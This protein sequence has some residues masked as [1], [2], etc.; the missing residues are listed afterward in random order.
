MEKTSGK[1]LIQL[2]GSWGGGQ[3]LGI[4]TLSGDD[5]NG[6]REHKLDLALKATAT[7]V[8]GTQ[9][10]EVEMNQIFTNRETKWVRAGRSSEGAYPHKTNHAERMY[11]RHRTNERKGEDAES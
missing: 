7:S 11:N 6:K 3:G 9:E 1:S 10:E 5:E 4:S 8:K 2:L